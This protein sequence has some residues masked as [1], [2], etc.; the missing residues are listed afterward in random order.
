MH[1]EV[2]ESAFYSATFVARSAE[3]SA[4]S[5][6]RVDMSDEAGEAA[7]L[8]AE[9]ASFK[10]ACERRDRQW[11]AAFNQ[12]EVLAN[13]WRMDNGELDY[14]LNHERP[15]PWDQFESVARRRVLEE[16]ARVEETPTE[17]GSDSDEIVSPALGSVGR[18][19]SSKYAGVAR[20]KDKFQ[21]RIHEGGR[22]NYL[23]TFSSEIE[24]A[25]AHDVRARQIGRLKYLNFPN[26]EEADAAAPP[27]SSQFNGVCLQRGFYVARISEKGKD[28]TLGMFKDETEAALA[29]DA[30]AR[31]IGRHEKLNFPTADDRAGAGVVALVEAHLR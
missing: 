7:R 28:H 5:A 24:A 12:I 29:Y 31:Q 1:G 6:P 18:V 4:F 10:D 30:R 26:A 11:V 20:K 15:P 22:E 25:K 8:R 23:G 9:L 17:A 19:G 16:D 27:P 13:Y 21:A 2:D 3:S 14:P